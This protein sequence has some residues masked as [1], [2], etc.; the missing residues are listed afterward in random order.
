MG[1]Q[2]AVKA[3][4]K[5][6]AKFEGRASRSEYWWPMLMFIIAYVIMIIASQLGDLIGG[7]VGLA[8]VVFFLGSLIP[9]IAVGVRRLHDGDKS[10]WFY[11]L[12]FIPIV[13][14]YYLYLV[15]IKGTD[16]PNQYGPD[17]LGSDASVFN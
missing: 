10:G 14:L 5:N 1:F 4:Y 17:P 9:A 16:G 8:M 13:S 6:Y 11:L 15:I 12:S 3:F 2:E 7:I